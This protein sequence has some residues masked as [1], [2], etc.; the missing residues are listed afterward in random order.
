MSEGF[1]PCLVDGVRLAAYA[2][3]AINIWQQTT[4][5]TDRALPK[6]DEL[7]S[8]LAKT[9]NSQVVFLNVITPGHPI[10]SSPQRKELEAFY[11]R[12]IGTWRAVVQVAEGTDLWSVTAR[13]VMVAARLVQRRPYPT[14][15]FS[16]T[17]EGV[18]WASEYLTKPEGVSTEEV[19]KGLQNA[20]NELRRAAL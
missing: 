9:C 1:E 10:P 8:H 11:G 19:A 3:C 12:W 17:E 18:Q 2:N 13:S 4:S 16:A 7:V 20:M 5:K 15:V 14:R 6:I